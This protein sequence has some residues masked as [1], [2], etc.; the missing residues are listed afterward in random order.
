MILQN[1][2]VDL[3]KEVAE[4][5]QT[6]PFILITGDPGCENSQIFICCEND[7]LMESKTIRD[8]LLDLLAAY[9]TFDIAY[10]KGISGILIFLQHFVL[11]LEDQQV[12]PSMT[13]KLISNLSKLKTDYS[14]HVQL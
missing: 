4:I 14:K 3:D 6:A 11:G 1:C 8:A 5:E 12:I 7:I 2:D 13:S 9:F 10:P